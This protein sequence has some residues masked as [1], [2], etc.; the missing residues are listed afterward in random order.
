MDEFVAITYLTPK[1]LSV[2]IAS[3]FGSPLPMVYAVMMNIRTKKIHV[4]GVT[5]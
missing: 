1:K 2:I 3:T 5:L 4:L